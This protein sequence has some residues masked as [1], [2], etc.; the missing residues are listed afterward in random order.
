MASLKGS[1]HGARRR[2]AGLSIGPL[3]LTLGLLTDGSS[4]S[5]SV[6]DGKFCHNQSIS[7]RPMGNFA[8]I[9]SINHRPMGNFAIIS[10]STIGRWGAGA[11]SAASAIGRWPGGQ[12]SGHLSSADGRG[13]KPSV[14]QRSSAIGRLWQKAT[15]IF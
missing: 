5:I 10:P 13:G 3:G 6:S 1:G 8:I 9:R 4:I 2:R 12:T 11:P 14:H 15:K 7:H